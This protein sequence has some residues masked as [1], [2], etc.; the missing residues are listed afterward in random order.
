MVNPIESAW[1]PHRPTM[2]TTNL[3]TLLSPLFRIFPISLLAV[4]LEKAANDI[5]NA[6]WSQPS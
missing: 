1:D 3:L 4:G 6:D 5:A 2:L